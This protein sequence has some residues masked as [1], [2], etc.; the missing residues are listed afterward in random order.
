MPKYFGHIWM[1]HDIHIWVK[2]TIRPAPENKI[3]LKPTQDTKIPPLE[4]LHISFAKCILLREKGTEMKETQHEN[5]LK[6]KNKF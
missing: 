5:N 6:W 4:I 3:V 1:C 2:I